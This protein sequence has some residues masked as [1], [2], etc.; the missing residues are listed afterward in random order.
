MITGTLKAE[1]SGFTFLLHSKQLDKT[2]FSTVNTIFD[3]SISNGIQSN[4]LLLAEKRYIS[5]I[6]IKTTCKMKDPFHSLR[7]K[8]VNVKNKTLFRWR[9]SIYR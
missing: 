5:N 2:N 6:C 9:T 4:L 1:P 3:E 8:I 7:F